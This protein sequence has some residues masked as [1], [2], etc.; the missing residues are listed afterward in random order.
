MRWHRRGVEAH[1]TLTGSWIVNKYHPMVESKRKKV[2]Q[3]RSETGTTNQKLFF[4]SLVS[5]LANFLHGF[6]QFALE[7]AL[8]QKKLAALLN[9]QKV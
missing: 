8:K 9:I 5:A 2:K 3:A 1:R 4:I 7:L 6:T